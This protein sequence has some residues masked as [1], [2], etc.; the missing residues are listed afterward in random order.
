M[1]LHREP[2][3]NLVASAAPI[4]TTTDDADALDETGETRTTPR[5]IRRRR[6]RTKVERR[7]DTN[8]ELSVVEL[9]SPQPIAEIDAPVAAEAP[10]DVTELAAEPA[11]QPQ[12][13]S[14]GSRWDRPSP[15]P[16]ARST[17]LGST[18]TLRQ[19]PTR[20][21]TRSE[22]RADATAPRSSGSPTR[23]TS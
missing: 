13:V 19:D 18:S 7:I 17:A 2:V 22:K 3:D 20:P 23:T 11:S 15:H 1:A 9:Q 5:R 8:D 16:P 10:V 6:R 4:D 14:H 12:P 21:S